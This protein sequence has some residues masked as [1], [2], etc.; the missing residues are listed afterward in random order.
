MVEKIEQLVQTQEVQ[1]ARPVVLPRL[2][3]PRKTALVRFP[4]G[5]I[6]EAPVGTPLESFIRAAYNDDPV[7]IVA[8]LIN[9]RLYELTYPV[10]HDVEVTPISMGHSDGMRIYRRSLTFLLVVAAH[11][12]FPD[13][14]V[15]VDHSLTFGGLFCEV[16]GRDPLTPQEVEL[17]E[18]RMKEIAAEDA[19]I[20]K[21]YV[22]LKEAIALFQACDQEDKVRLLRYRRRDYVTLYRLYDLDDYFHG[23]MVPSTGYLHHFA[24]QHYS[25]GFILRYPRHEQP[26]MLQPVV[27]YPKLV[28]VFREYGHWLR[29]LG[30]DD[31]GSLN[32]ALADGRGGEVALV[33]EALHEQRIAQIAA[34][35]AK[36]RDTVRLVLIAGPSA[37]GK[38]TFS[39]R[40]AIQLLANGLR[41]VAVELDNYFVDRAKTPLSQGGEYD[42][43]H[44]GAVDL[45]LLNDQLL[46]LMDGREVRLPRYNFPQGRREEGELLKLSKEHVILL[47]GIHGLNP[48][49]VP[50][51]PKERIYRIYVSA[52]T[53]LNLDHYNRVPTTDTRLIRRIV[54][55]ARERGYSA[56]DTLR[57]W[58]S[59]RDGEKRWIFPY[60]EHADV[61]FN[62]ALVYELSALKPL[63]EP[64]LF[65]I[66]SNVP[67]YVEARRLLALLRW[68]LPC[69]VDLIPTNSI[70]C[71]FIGGSSLRGFTVWRQK[72]PEEK[73][74]GWSLRKL[75]RTYV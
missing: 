50:S 14:Q 9:C 58:E 46:K 2:S 48:G 60:Q 47:E 8:A 75:R 26:T 45:D 59:V 38:T 36:R 55:D 35:I 56:L 1:V 72:V 13:A 40:L 67:E 16:Y 53:Q 23:Y 4:D 62:S 70:L 21:R 18:Q 73:R 25:T 28:A 10:T 29:I 74:N 30:I 51:V 7:L 57:R 43:E 17:L 11:Q 27:E 66:E 61:M 68:F 64:L 3:R 71:E 54:R 31:V 33:S 15:Y 5:R 22:P 20:H 37:S 44:L 12:L 42:F 41:P 39:K 19:P 24:L 69:A 63:A 52:L 65:Q 49:L 32:D 34:E 6:F